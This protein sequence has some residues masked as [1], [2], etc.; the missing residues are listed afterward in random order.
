MQAK[1]TI[2]GQVPKLAVTGYD[3]K[4]IDND[5]TTFFWDFDGV[6][7]ENGADPEICAF[8]EVMDSIDI[9]ALELAGCEIIGSIAVY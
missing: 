8:D 2:K 9:E 6:A 7:Y 4:V 1:I 5:T 3:S